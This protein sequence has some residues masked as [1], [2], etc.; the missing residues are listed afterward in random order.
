LGERRENFLR[1]SDPI[2]THSPHGPEH[3]WIVDGRAGQSVTI[4]VE[5]YE[6][7]A[8]LRVL[9][10]QGRQ[11][12]WSD[13][14]GWFFNGRVQVMLPA[15]GRYTVIVSGTNADQSGTYWLSLV[16]GDQTVSRDESTVQAYYQR[17]LEWARRQENQRAISWMNLM[18]G[19]YC[20]ERGRWAQAE[21][22]CGKSLAAAKQADFFYGQ[23]AVAL[24]R[25]TLLPARM[26]YGEAADE[27]QRALELSKKLRAANQA[28]AAVFAQLGDLYHHILRDDLAGIH[29]RNAT[30]RAEQSKHPS[31][32]AR[33]YT[34]LFDYLGLRDKERAVEYAQQAYA[35]RHGLD[36]VLQLATSHTLAIAYS[37]SGRSREGVELASTTRDQAHRLGCRNVEVSALTFMSME[38]GRSQKI[39]D[40]IRSAREAVELTDPDDGDPSLRRIA[41]QMLASGEM[42]RGN[43]EAALQLCLSALQ[44]TEDAWTRQPIEE[45]RHAL[46][47]QSKAICTQIIMN[48]Y[49]LNRRHPSS[50]YARQAFDFAEQ[51]RSRSLLN[52]L[53]AGPEHPGSSMAASLLDRDQHLQEKI[54]ALGRQLVLLRTESR[55]DR[56]TLDGLEEQ[57]ARLVGERMQLQAEVR[58][59][60][61]NAYDA[62]QLS[63]LTAE[64]VQQ[65]FLATHPNAAILFYQLGI[66]ESFL[67]V[68]TRAEAH[69]FKLPDWT[70]ISNTVTKWRAKIRGQMN[71]RGNQAQ[72]A[73]AYQDIAHQL[74]TML[75]KPARRLIQGRDLIII[76]DRAISHTALHELAFEGLVTS[77]LEQVSNFDQLHYLVQDHAVT[78]TPSLSVLAEIERRPARGASDTEKKLLLVGDAVF[79][80]R[81]P[82]V[83]QKQS[84][85]QGPENELAM[86][87][88]S[89]L[90]IGIN[91]LLATRDEVLGIA[92]LAEEYKWSPQVWL[93][94][95]ASEHNLKAGDLSTY[96]LVHLATHATADPV[97]GDFSGIILSLGQTA[98]GD[99]GLLTAAEV[100]R[101]KLKADLVVLSGCRTGGGQVAR[102]EG[103]IGL[104]RAFLVAG[105]QRVC[106]SL[107]SVEDGST[108]ELM[109]T[110]YLHLLTEKE[111]VAD[112]LRQ[113]KIKLLRRGREPFYWTP[114]ILVGSS[115]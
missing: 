18:M 104:S 46:L 39:E 53:G 31:L 35:L 44:A 17:G 5:S 112:A 51:S 55:P 34:S 37:L 3:R 38:Y 75:I 6:F 73:R 72:A 42:M 48:L 7:D 95:D 114:F 88:R 36:P 32:L 68:L 87:D 90:R 98:S 12:A 21:E 25:G 106:A 67:I 61:A 15:T 54:S 89:E 82:R 49:A 110:L 1:P 108:R 20:R 84:A 19:K 86:L 107:W 100:S 14:S 4:T 85:E 28:E 43:H 30:E 65:E 50:E 23:W 2:P 27:L 22:Y 63:P 10:P 16:E 74:Y 105:A 45:L 60:A 59:L 66:Q 9:D 102:A 97:V 109:T 81:D 115:D 33:V 57:R 94:F 78:Y 99:D 26:R 62:A 13:D 77:A 79:N 8:F 58:R 113:A 80:D 11:I 64:Q 69:L 56:A 83:A 71:L 96:R 76:P 52:Q 41:L 111:S 92:R 103:I 101:L 47:S 40:M 91:R 24:E 70:T 29:Y 93:D